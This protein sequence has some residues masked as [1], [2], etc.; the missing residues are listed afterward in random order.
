MDI[1]RR[2][3]RE[4]NVNFNEKDLSDMTGSRDFRNKVLHEGYLPNEGEVDRVV[5]DTKFL[6]SFLQDKEE[7]LKAE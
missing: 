1:L 6:I 2:F 4:R 3:L 7:K 5:G